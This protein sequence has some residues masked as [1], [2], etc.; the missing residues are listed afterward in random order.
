VASKAAMIQ[1]DTFFVL[2]CIKGQLMA[3]NQGAAHGGELPKLSLCRD[4][5]LD[6]D[7][8]SFVSGPRY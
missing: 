3:A 2:L 6:N 1:H 8:V 7:C 5:M 4:S